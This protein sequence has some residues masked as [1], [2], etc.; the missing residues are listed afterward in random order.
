MDGPRKFGSLPSDGLSPG[1][2]PSHRLDTDDG[3]SFRGPS[4]TSIL[5]PNRR[6]SWITQNISICGGDVV[7]GTPVAIRGAAPKFNFEEQEKP[8]RGLHRR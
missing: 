3:R 7:T 2:Y 5:D 6:G 1:L 4:G 8:E